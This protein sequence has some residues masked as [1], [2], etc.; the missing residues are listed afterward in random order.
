M[1]T[2]SATATNKIEAKTLIAESA[3]RV[4]D[5]ILGGGA[6]RI[7][8]VVSTAKATSDGNAATVSGGTVVVGAFVGGVPVTIGENG[9]SVA[10][11]V[12]SGPLAPVLDPITPVLQTLGISMRLTPP[13]KT[14]EGASG[15]ISTGG[16]VVT[17]DNTPFLSNLPPEIKGQLPADPSGT[18]S[19]IF[20]QTSAKASA[21]PGFGEALPLEDLVEDT[22]VDTGAD[23]AVAGDVVSDTAAPISGQVSATESTPA[24]PASSGRT[25]P[26]GSAVTVGLVLLALIG[27][28]LV[29][30]GLRKLGTGVF[31][32]VATTN[33]PLESG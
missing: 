25:L 24:Q 17:I 28:T 6:V 30:Y 8:G 22:P 19:L 11:Q 13:T 31:E 29:A 16:L 32:P 33:C 23:T 27:S 21:T 2:Q 4:N 18:L 3:S 12:D 15:E 10:G 26:S 14:V 5:I 9:V 7:G 1:G 20:G